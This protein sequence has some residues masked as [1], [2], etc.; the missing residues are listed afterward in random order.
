MRDL[1]RRLRELLHDKMAKEAEAG[2][3]EED[4]D[5]E[6]LLMKVCHES[7]D[8]KMVVV[9]DGEEAEGEIEAHSMDKTT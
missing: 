8:N 2:A 7:P 4:V 5:K 6:V 3:E 1:Q 9:A